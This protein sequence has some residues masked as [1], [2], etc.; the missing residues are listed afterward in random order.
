MQH[1]LLRLLLFYAT[2]PGS[3]VLLLASAELVMRLEPVTAAVPIPEGIY[4]QLQAD[5]RIF[6]PSRP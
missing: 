3:V 6:T 1:R 4:V 5:E 2:L